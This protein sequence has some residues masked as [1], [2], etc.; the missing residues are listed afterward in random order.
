MVKI[1]MAS[2][3]LLI[4]VIAVEMLGGIL[5]IAGYKV[6]WASYALIG[7]TL[8]ATY[9]FHFLAGDVLQT[10]KNLAI[11]GGLFYVAA[12]G[13]GMW[14]VDSWRK[15]KMTQTTPTVN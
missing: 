15:M 1:P 10:L 8:L 9:Y 12:N 6:R 13:A 14:S 7:F 5:L 11:I 3:P 4:L 2:L